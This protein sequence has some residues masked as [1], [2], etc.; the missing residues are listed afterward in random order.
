MDRNII[1]LIVLAGGI[2]FAYMY[3]SSKQHFTETKKCPPGQHLASPY[4][5]EKPTICINNGTELVIQEKSG[6]TL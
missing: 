1:L 4:I 6:Y 3:F 2:Y 5:A